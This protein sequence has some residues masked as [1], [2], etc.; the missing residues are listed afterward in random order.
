VFAQFGI[1]ETVVSDNG[2]HFISEEFYTFLLENGV[3]QILSSPY[4]PATKGMAECAVETVK[5]GL[6][7]DCKGYFL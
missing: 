2:S 3:K 5:W 7:K 1:P 4:H 6:K